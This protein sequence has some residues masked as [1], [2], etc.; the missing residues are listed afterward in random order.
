MRKLTLIVLI[1]A[2]TGC[3]VARKNAGVVSLETT[4]KIS[5]SHQIMA[6]NI[7][8]NDFNILKAEIDIRNDTEG[9]RMVGNM[10]YKKPGTYL[11]SIRNQTGIEAARIFINEDTVLINDRIN[12]KLYFGSTDYLFG[13]YGITAAI[14]PIILGDFITDSDGNEEIICVNNQASYRKENGN[15]ELIYNIDCGKRK[16][17]DVRSLDPVTGK[18]IIIK[19]EKFDKI[20]QIAIPRD[21]KIMDSAAETSI[22]LNIIKIE[23]GPESKI[24]FIP[25][26]NYEQ[27]LLK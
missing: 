18:G 11:I 25:G 17:T 12:K 22:H 3:S 10:K 4:G 27:V 13:K 5:L 14:L 8:N 16:V 26:K 24:I 15:K 7:S 23:T 19:F 9:Q 21:I 2:I 1:V 6:F 20:D